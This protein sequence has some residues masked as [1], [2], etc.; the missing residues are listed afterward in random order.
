MMRKILALLCL[1]AVTALALDNGL[2]K[3]PQMGWNSVCPFI[4]IIF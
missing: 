2:G 4:I 3:T 1:G